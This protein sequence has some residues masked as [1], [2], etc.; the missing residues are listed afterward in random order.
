MIAVEVASR[1]V[2]KCKEEREGAGTFKEGGEYFPVSVNTVI[3]F[4]S[5][6]PVKPR[7]WVIRRIQHVSFADASRSPWVLGSRRYLNAVRGFAARWFLIEPWSVK[8]ATGLE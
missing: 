6:R 2:L 4:L 8:Y 3:S 7:F 5:V 1:D